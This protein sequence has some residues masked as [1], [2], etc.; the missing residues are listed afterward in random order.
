[1][2][3][4]PSAGSLF[5]NI[6]FEDGPSET[7]PR[8]VVRLTTN[9]YISGGKAVFAKTVTRLKRRSQLTFDEINFD[10]DAEIDFTAIVNLMSV[11][12]GIY[13][14]DPHETDSDGDEYSSWWYAI[15]WKLVPWAE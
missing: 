5:Q 13:Y 15:T 1:M 4:R 6:T 9:C 10:H 14:L 12:D 11:G 2:S 8:C 3:N 7:D